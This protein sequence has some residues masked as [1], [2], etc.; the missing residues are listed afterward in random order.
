[1]K[2]NKQRKREIK[3][4]RKL[5]AEKI[6]QGHISGTSFGKIRADHEQ[7]KHINTYGLLPDFYQSILFKCRDCDSDEIWTAQQQKWYYEVAKGHIDAK[8]VRCRKCRDILK[9]TKKL[10]KQHMQAM[11]EIVPHSNEVFF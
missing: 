3:D 8:A 11:A 2:S 7:L 1:M 10:Q 4:K 9:N 6:K 5:K